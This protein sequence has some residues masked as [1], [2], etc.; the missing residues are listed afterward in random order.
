VKDGQ[1]GGYNGNGQS[2]QQQ[3][4]TF[5]TW[6]ASGTPSLN[7]SPSSPSP[8]GGDRKAE[9]LCAGMLWQPRPYVHDNDPKQVL[10]HI[11]R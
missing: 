6:T 8:D 5:S 10:E 9:L 7:R 11:Q 1:R 3:Q 2:H 4:F